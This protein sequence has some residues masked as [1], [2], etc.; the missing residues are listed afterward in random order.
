MLDGFDNKERWDLADYF[1]PFSP[2]DKL[3]CTF[4]QEDEGEVEGKMKECPETLSE[5]PEVCAVHPIEVQHV[6]KILSNS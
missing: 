6:D 1:N 3:S 2:E 4:H 5:G